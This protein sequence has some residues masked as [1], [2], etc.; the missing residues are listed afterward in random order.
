MARF[1]IKRK[2]LDVDE[3]SIVSE[4]LT[5]G[6]TPGNNVVLNNPTVSRTHAGITQ[7][8]NE[9]IV[10]NLAPQNRTLVNG[11]QVDKFPV[12]DGDVIQ[13]GPFFLI[14]G[15]TG[16]DLELTV[17]MEIASKPVTIEEGQKDVPVLFSKSVALEV[18]RK[19]SF[20]LSR[21]AGTGFLTKFLPPDEEQALKVFWDKRKREAGKIE[22][23]F[24]LMP[25]STEKVGKIQFNWRPTTDL[26]RIWRKSY[27]AWGII[28]SCSLSLLGL[29]LWP[30][31]FSPGKISSAHAASIPSPRK[32]ALRANENS[33]SNCHSLKAMQQN[34][35]SCHSTPKFDPSISKAHVRAEIGC[36]GCHGEHQGEDFKPGFVT[37]TLCISCH[38]DSF[39]FQG[40]P[41]GTPHGGTVGYPIENGKWV[42]AGVEEARWKNNQL[43]GKPSDFSLTNQFHLVHFH[44]K[45]EEEREVFTRCIDCHET[46]DRNAKRF[47]EAPKAACATCHATSFSAQNVLAVGP[48]CATCHEQHGGYKELIASPRNIDLQPPSGGG[49]S[50]QALA[51]SVKNIPMGG[52]GG[53]ELN[54]QNQTAPRLNSILSNFGGLP[55]VVWILLL[56]VLPG[57]AIVSVAVDAIRRKSFLTTYLIKPKEEEKEFKLGTRSINLAQIRAEGPKYPYPVID[58]VLCIGCHACVEACPHDVL[59]MVNGISTAVAPAQCMEDTSCQAECPTQPKACIVLNTNKVI[60]PR[61]VPKRDQTFMTNVPGIYI[62]GDVS[63]VPLIKMAINEG[64]KVID[65]IASALQQEG[66][67]PGT[68]CDVAIIGVGPG[69]LAAAATASEKGLRYVALEQ[70]KIVSTIQAYPA[71]K[72]VF[73]KPDSVET[74]GVV[75]LP[76][77]GLQKETILESW[78]DV[79]RK[80]SLKINEEETCKNIKQ[81]DGIFLITTE[82]GPQSLS[83]KSR[84]V[85][86]AVGNRGAPM[87]LGVPG[88]DLTIPIDSIMPMEAICPNCNKSSATGGKFC[89]SCGTRMPEVVQQQPG[90]DPKVKYK[91]SNPDDYVNKH[92]IVVGGGNSAIEAAVDLCGFKREGE[93]I[94][95]TRNNIVTL[96]V[97][98]DFKGDLKLGNK[99]NIYDCMDAGKVKVYFGAAIN[100]DQRKGSERG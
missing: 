60:P 69:G 8:G 38:N 65:S 48:N 10:F 2:D 45:K 36:I 81:E 28:I 15:L 66:A 35:V 78:M 44:L 31:S 51:A 89:M 25:K 80:F 34:C 53:A 68:D 75:P 62:I 20:G 71:G 27:F 39:Q 16:P 87:R 21:V 32:I 33:C 64:T 88:E 91:L 77:V 46:G 40:K 73:F 57:A 43:P 100:E 59:A 30:Q 93:E 79:I 61:K 4:G 5:L 94:R 41:L 58:P 67:K 84:K 26:R 11:E 97:R 83:Y 56:T 18:K 85:I 29:A 55:V 37:S 6:R 13:I 76:G 12:G 90:N 99:I 14:A 1:V 98:S 23:R 86:V 42:W 82:K 63:G 22:S 70:E 47:V 50:G 52:K 95:F 96:L 49:P 92:C 17:Q 3:I 74:K 54:R 72:Y 19:T 9:F 7:V 24:A